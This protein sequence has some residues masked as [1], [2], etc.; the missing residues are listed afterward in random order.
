MVKVFQAHLKQ[1]RF[2]III[3]YVF[4]FS[5]VIQNTSLHLRF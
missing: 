4:I 1:C 5:L 2:E 3:K